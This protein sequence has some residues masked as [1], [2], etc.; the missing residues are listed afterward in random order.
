M[1]SRS[2][3]FFLFFALLLSFPA[4][5]ATYDLKEI[6]PEVQKA[7]DNRKARYE[8]LQDFKS[9]GLI[10]ENN[11]GFV[12]VIGDATKAGFAAAPENGDRRVIYQAIVDQN[13]LGEGGMQQV[14]LAFAEVQREKARKGDKIQTPEGEW[15]KK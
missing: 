1:K 6:T 12:T 10:G 9:Q 3:A 7:L 14:M 4:F 2:I 13:G 8:E 15:G 11:E 5:A